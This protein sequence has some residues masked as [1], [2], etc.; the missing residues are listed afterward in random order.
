MQLQQLRYLIAAADEGSFRSASAKLYVSQ[1]SVSVAVRDLE[2]ETGVTVF[3][4]TPRG[5]SLTVEGEELVK[6]ARNVVEQADLMERRYA[7]GRTRSRARFSVSSQHYSLVVDAFGDFAAARSESPCELTLR[8]S[9]TA[10]IVRDVSG[11]R[12]DLGVMHLS[13]HNERVVTRILDDAGLSFTSL[14]VAT[15]HAVMWSGYPLVRKKSVTLADLAPYYRI[16]QEA[17]PESSDFLSED[18]LSSIPHDRRIVVR[19]NGTLSTLLGRCD[20]YA[21]GTGAFRDEGDIVAVPLETDEFMNVGYIRRDDVPL[22][23][24]AQE[25][26]TLLARRILA[27]TGPIETSSAAYELARPFQQT[28]PDAPDA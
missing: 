28:M 14:Y 2:R 12:S 5:T 23:A 7:R 10:D 6:Y 15:P 3:E 1:S 26:L 8:E 18:P 27:F 19:D 21:L 22:G 25:F 17:G 11:L 9:G 4:R 13:S 20:A 24:L 16:E